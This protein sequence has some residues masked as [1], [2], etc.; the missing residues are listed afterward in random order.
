MRVQVA[1]DF[2]AC[3]NRRAAHTLL[4]AFAGEAA[5]RALRA[6]PAA[7]REGKAARDRSALDPVGSEAPRDPRTSTEGTLG[8][9]GFMRVP[10]KCT[11][12]LSAAQDL[13]NQGNVQRV[14]H[15]PV[16]HKQKKCGLIQEACGVFLFLFLPR[17]QERHTI[18][19]FSSARPPGK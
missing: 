3:D 6:S 7:S 4:S 17:F 10:L 15:T 14:A 19:E 18:I 2:T 13:E 9:S 5:S 16:F 11:E 12:C 1:T 8:A